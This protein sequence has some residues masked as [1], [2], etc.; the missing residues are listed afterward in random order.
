M[1]RI[2]RLTEN[3]LTKLV[4]R[5][6]NENNSQGYNSKISKI[7]NNFIKKNNEFKE[8]FLEQLEEMIDDI[9]NNKNLESKEK[10]ELLRK[11]D[12]LYTKIQNSGN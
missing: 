1:K 7:E 12:N 4:K 2:I 5:V 9:R 3:D 8:D 11:I 6:I 10:N